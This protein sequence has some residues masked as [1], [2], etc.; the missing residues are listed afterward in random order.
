MTVQDSGIPSDLFKKQLIQRIGK[1][2]RSV[3]GSQIVIWGSGAYGRWLLSFLKEIGLSDKVKCF[4]DSFHDDNKTDF[5]DGLPVY[6]P[7]KCAALYKDATFIIASDYYEEILSAI[8]KSPYHDIKTFIPDYDDRMLQKQLIYY[9]NAPDPQR[10]VS[11]NY[12][13]FPIYA[14]AQ[15][16]GRLSEYLNY[17]LPLLDDQNS[18]AIIQNRIKTFL[19]GDLAYIDKNPLDPNEYFSKDF[20]PIGDDE[21]LFDC[22][23]FTG[24][25]VRKFS[26]FTHNKYRKIVAFEPDEKNLEKMNAYI[27]DAGLENIEVVK[28]AT[29]KENGFISFIST[30]TMGA[31]I[32]SDCNTDS[33]K[34]RVKL[35]KLDDFID[36][37]PT[38]IK[39][40]IEGAELDAL[41]GATEII[42]K[43]KPKLAICIYHLPF[44]FYNIPKFIKYLVP[45]YRFKVRQYIPGFYDTVLYASVP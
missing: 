44:D 29:G 2:Y 5:T 36:Y 40:D 30:G 10:V 16:S 22:G 1:V 21:T 34:T 19:T 42:K 35:V 14:E 24:D 43:Y 8:A 38:L 41:A 17:V 25:T 28:A 6:S 11:F 45:E 18:R 33:E 27:K 31:K 9:K 20:Y 15:K 26:E 7:S 4:C 37:H 39:M 13:W 12:T 23:A 3:S 32:V